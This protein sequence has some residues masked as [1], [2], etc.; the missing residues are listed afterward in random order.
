M[1]GSRAAKVC[2]VLNE[3]SGEE[4]IYIRGRLLSVHSDAIYPVDLERELKNAGLD[5]KPIFFSRIEVDI[6][7]ELEG[8]PMFLSDLTK[9]NNSDQPAT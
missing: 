7:D 9:Q 4:A 5:G 3:N 8:F 6:E 2:I 1:V